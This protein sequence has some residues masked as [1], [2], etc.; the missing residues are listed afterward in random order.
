MNAYNYPTEADWEEYTG[1]KWS[2]YFILALICGLV[3]LYITLRNL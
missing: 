2:P 3:V 1:K